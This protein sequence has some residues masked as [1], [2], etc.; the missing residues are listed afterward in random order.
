[1]NPQIILDFW[2]GSPQDQDYGKPKE[3]WFVKNKDFDQKVRSLFLSTYQKAVLGELNHWQ[4]TPYDCLALILI[5]DQFPRNIFRHQ[6]QAFATDEHA[7]SCTKYAISQQFDQILLPVQRWF[8]Y[9]PFEHSE[10]LEDQKKSLE[11]FLTLQDYPDS[12]SSIDY[13]YRHYQVIKKFGRFPHRNAILGRINTPEEEAF[14]SQPQ[15]SF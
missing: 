3:S 11:L 6:P 7:L 9:L 4:N 14:L 5:Y 2:F 10:R 13:A 12:Q 15:S 8:I 1:M